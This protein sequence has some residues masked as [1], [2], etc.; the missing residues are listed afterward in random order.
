MRC[1]HAVRSSHLAEHSPTGMSVWPVSVV[2][3]SGSNMAARSD[4]VV[5]GGGLRRQVDRAVLGVFKTLRTQQSYLA[6]SIQHNPRS[7]NRS[8]HGH[9]TARPAG[10]E[11]A[12]STPP[13]LLRV[14]EAILV[15]SAAAME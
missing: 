12:E 2:V 14:S 10:S 8:L 13:R 7:H 4:L 1:A 3:S 5:D 15:P 11:R 6:H 9:T